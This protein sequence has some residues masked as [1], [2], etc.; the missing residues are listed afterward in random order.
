MAPGRLGGR[1][2]WAAIG[3]LLTGAACL[4]SIVLDR[5]SGLGD[6][7]LLVLAAAAFTVVGALILYRTDGN[8]VGWVM[9]ATALSLFV[10]AVADNVSGRGELVAQAVGGALWLGWFVLLGLLL[11]WFP[12]G[13]PVSPRWRF[14]GWLAVALALVC[15]SYLVAERLCIEPEGNSCKTWADNPIGIPG[16]PNPEF[17]DYS[18][19]G[20][21]VMAA[22]V[23]ISTASLVARFIRSRG[24]ERFQLKW[25]AFA[26]VTLITA[27]VA[28]ET[29]SEPLPL[30]TAIWDV[31]WGLAVLA[32]PVAIGF[33][34][35]RYRLYD[36]DR[37]V[38]RTLSYLV[39]VAC[40][41]AVFFV[42]VAGI[43]SLLPAQSDLAVAASTLA[44]AALFNPVR[45][46]VQIRVESR[47]NR[48][49]YDAQKVIDAFA[50]SLRGDTDPMGIAIGWREVVT[51]TMEPAAVSVWVRS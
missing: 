12:T 1:N 28:Q 24:V 43:T 13:R 20:Y 35:L 32:L 40:L 47:F 45:R 46:R 37:I 11:Y 4:T 44:V 29:L 18:T 34:V 36:I 10:G 50:A 2:R 26:V 33:S 42:I 14:L 6:E 5:D 17:G 25:F 16:V 3:L 48:A 21:M 9:A 51:E 41:G 23:V 30:P 19:F 49:R 39:V 38:S 31:I 27:T 15:A 22:F 7:P 8:R